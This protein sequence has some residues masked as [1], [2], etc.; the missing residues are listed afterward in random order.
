[1]QSRLPVELYGNVFE[2]LPPDVKLY[3]LLFLHRNLW[4]YAER[5]LYRDLDLSKNRTPWKLVI[6]LNEDHRLAGYVHSL[7]VSAK[8]LEII[9]LKRSKLLRLGLND[10]LTQLVP[11]L[12]R[13]LKLQFLEVVGDF[14][15]AKFF[16]RALKGIL[17]FKLI[18][19]RLDD[20]V[21]CTAAQLV[22][23]LEAQPL[24]E[25][26]EILQMNQQVIKSLSPG[27]L[28]RLRVVSCG[29][30]SDHH[31][32]EE[33]GVERFYCR[34][35]QPIGIRPTEAT[36]SIRCLV[37]DHFDQ[38]DWFQPAFEGLR[39]L[40]WMDDNVRYVQSGMVSAKPQHT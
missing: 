7:K 2:L 28:S 27:A 25:D 22:D 26:L 9:E 1:M 6:R 24:L 37:I 20:L 35:V 33:R 13:M 5:R 32:L 10:S 14:F 30:S 31:L 19:L 17:P 34:C 3:P 16:A 36:G 4:H 21:G 39:F 15:D 38:I 8:S 29:C 12:R 18:R 23:F 11:A 40:Q